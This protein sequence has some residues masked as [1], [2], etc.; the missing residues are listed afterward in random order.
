MLLTSLSMLTLAV[1]SQH[2]AVLDQ[3]LLGVYTNEEQVYF[4]KDAGRTPPPWIALKIEKQGDDLIV[5]R[6]DAFGKTVAA[7]LKGYAAVGVEQDSLTLGGCTRYFD[8]GDAGWTYSKLQNKK[9]CLQDFQIIGVTADELKLRFGD[10]TETRLK[11]ARP[12]ECWAAAKKSKPKA[13]GS[14][15]W[16]F[17]RKLNLHDQGGRVTI[18]GGD[19]GIEPLVLRMRAVYWPKPSTNRP[20][21]VL[22]VHKPDDPDRAV[23]YS[24]ADINASRVGLNLRWM[25]ASCTIKGAEQTSDVTSQNFRG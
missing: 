10:G 12:V 3:H 25:Q 9:A 23:S 1:G 11:R 2:G 16:M 17:V 19:T 4:E 18:G 5:T 21:M 14:P 20:S 8:R 24:W 13:D 15:D 7:P 6:T 22:Y